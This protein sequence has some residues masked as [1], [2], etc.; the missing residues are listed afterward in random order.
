[1]LSI[2]ERDVPLPRRATGSGN[3]A[4]HALASTHLLSTPLVNSEA[5]GSISG[6]GGVGRAP[7]AHLTLTGPRALAPARPRLSAPITLPLRCAQALPRTLHRGY[8]PCRTCSSSSLLLAA[9]PARRYRCS[10]P[11]FC[12]PSHARKS[13]A[14]H[15]RE[16]AF[17][18][19]A[20]EYVCVPAPALC[21]FPTR[22]RAFRSSFRRGCATHANPIAPQVSVSFLT[23][24][25][26][27]L[28][29]NDLVFSTPPLPL[30]PPTLHDPVA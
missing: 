14:N 28:A 9:T 15:L 4:S 8:H 13:Y 7:R 10:A 17:A 5:G 18:R 22:V 3:A 23:P 19:S 24:G 26:L 25:P 11:A 27:C 6:T 20:S 1:M 30:F 16:P 2:P 21:I 12:S 29:S